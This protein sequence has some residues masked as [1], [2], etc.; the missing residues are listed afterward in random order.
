MLGVREFCRQSSLPRHSHRLRWPIAPYVTS[1]DLRTSNRRFVNNDVD[2]RHF[3]LRYKPNVRGEE[4]SM[5]AKNL[6]ADPGKALT[7]KSKSDVEGKQVTR[8]PT[9]E[10]IQLRAYEIYVERGGIHGLDTDDWLQAE[11]E[12]SVPNTEEK[13]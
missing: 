3:V 4:R 11:R 12:L 2:C 7:S 5:K 6:A 13:S 9:T 10:E 8:T 1:Y